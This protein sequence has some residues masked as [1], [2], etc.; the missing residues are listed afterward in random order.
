ML[1]NGRNWVWAKVATKQIDKE[2][3]VQEMREENK[4]T[5]K[6]PQTGKPLTQ[7]ESKL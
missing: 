3:W 4:Q 5:N 6:K 1:S 7:N 2:E